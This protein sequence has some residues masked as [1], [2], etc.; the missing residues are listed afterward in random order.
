MDNTEFKLNRER[1]LT[2]ILSDSITLDRILVGLEVSNSA[3]SE[4]S[5]KG[6]EPDI[7]VSGYSKAFC[8]F[9]VEDDDEVI[10]QLGSIYWKHFDKE[11]NKTEITTPQELAQSIYIEW[12]GF[13]IENTQVST[14]GII[15]AKA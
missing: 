5:S 2:A 15:K 14:N 13:L 6:L 1:L 10:E 7:K 9:G 11:Q 4:V 3:L 12:V 8:L